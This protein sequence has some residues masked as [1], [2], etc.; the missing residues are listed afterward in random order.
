[1]HATSCPK[2]YTRGLYNHTIITRASS[3]RG[4][5]LPGIYCRGM[6][7]KQIYLNESEGVYWWSVMSVMKGAIDLRKRFSEVRLNFSNVID[8]RIIKQW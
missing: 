4:H 1:M 2:W 8:P 6:S 5:L 3:L 7:V